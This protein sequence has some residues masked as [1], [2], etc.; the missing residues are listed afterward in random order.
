MPITT[1]HGWCA[2]WNPNAHPNVTRT[3][4]Q[5]RTHARPDG[6]SIELCAPN[7]AVDGMHT[8]CPTAHEKNVRVCVFR[9]GGRRSYQN[10]RGRRRCD[11]REP[12]PTETDRHVRK[13]PINLRVKFPACL[14]CHIFGL[15]R[16]LR[17]HVRTRTGCLQII[18]SLGL[19][20]I[21]RSGQIYDRGDAATGPGSIES[22]IY[23]VD[24]DLRLVGWLGFR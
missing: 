18:Q 6:W 5:T 15:L 1:Q 2:P 14:F 12:K 20:I 10:L 13:R 16:A 3:R 19:I 9:R 4:T 11:R 8:H 23:A 21:C 22:T 17:T 24:C 7:F